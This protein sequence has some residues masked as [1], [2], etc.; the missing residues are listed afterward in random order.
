MQ[1]CRQPSRWVRL[2]FVGDPRGL[3]G[4]HG[5]SYGE[6]G[7]SGRQQACRVLAG[8]GVQGRKHVLGLREGATETAAVTTGLLKATW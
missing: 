8:Q 1:H 6:G 7:N 5:E 4:R 2:L 3:W